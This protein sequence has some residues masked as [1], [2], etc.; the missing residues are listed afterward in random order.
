MRRH[1]AESGEGGVHF[2]P[3]TAAAAAGGAAPPGCPDEAALARPPTEPGWQRWWIA[4]EPGGRVVGHCDL[5]GPRLQTELHRATLGVG[6]EKPHRRQ[7]LGTRLVLEAIEFARG[8]ATLDWIDLG[9]FSNNV[10]ALALYE[11]L[12]FRETGRVAD[13]FRIGGQSIEDIQMTIHVRAP[14][15]PA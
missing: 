14:A 9:V 10:P 5:K 8:V 6:L 15:P 11:W 4:V 7:G 1:V 2:M 13:R 3:W 12:G